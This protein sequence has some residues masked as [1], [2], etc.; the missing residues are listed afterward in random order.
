MEHKNTI[1]VEI[2]D[3]NVYFFLIELLICHILQ[4]E[5]LT[6]IYRYNRVFIKLSK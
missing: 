5:I 4:G 6:S 2:P 3:P 1:R